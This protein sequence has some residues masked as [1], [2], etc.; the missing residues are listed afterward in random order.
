[1]RQSKTLCLNRRN[2]FV[3]SKDYASYMEKRFAK[4]MCIAFKSEEIWTIG[5]NSRKSNSKE[6][7][8]GA[9]VFVAC[10]PADRLS[11]RGRKRQLSSFRKGCDR[12]HYPCSSS[13]TQGQIVG[14]RERLNGRIKWREEKTVLYFSS[15]H[16]FAARLVFPLPPLSAPGSPRIIL[17]LL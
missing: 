12:N 10:R 13:E 8:R 15:R 2:Q 9:V 1:M 17:A 6:P 5:E 7:E 4:G 11:T 14:A 3:Q 16:F